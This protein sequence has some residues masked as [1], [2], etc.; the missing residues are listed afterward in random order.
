MYIIYIL[1]PVTLV[2]ASNS[3]L[4]KLD[5][6]CSPKFTSA[7]MP[8]EYTLSVNRCVQPKQCEFAWSILVYV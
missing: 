4:H 1:L 7:V 6:P 2:V 8:I 3:Y 5:T